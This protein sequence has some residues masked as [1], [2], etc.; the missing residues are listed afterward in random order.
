MLYDKELNEVKNKIKNIAGSIYYSNELILKALDN[1]DTKIFEQ[2]KSKLKNISNKTN[3]I[4]NDIIKILALYSPEAKDLRQVVSYL[5]ITNELSRASTNTRSF[6]KGFTEVCSFTDVNIVKE[7]AIPMQKSTLKAILTA[8][9]MLDIDDEDELRDMFNDVL[10]QENKTA[11]LYEIVEKSLFEQANKLENFEIFH[12]MLKA[13][14]KSSKIAD[15]ATSI[16]QLILY[17]NIGGSLKVK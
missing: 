15:R 16:A 10:I 11:D 13:L 12:H 8:K 7:Y 5:K 3:E 6:I 14:R 9:V 1:C 4:D 17:I 2:A